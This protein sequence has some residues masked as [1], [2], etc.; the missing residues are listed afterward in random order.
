MAGTLAEAIHLHSRN[1]S[2]P[3]QPH[4]GI[5]RLPMTITV[6][7]T[8]AGLGKLRLDLESAHTSGGL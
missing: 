2:E 3:E 5:T 4:V 6:G 8:D 1:E 7:A